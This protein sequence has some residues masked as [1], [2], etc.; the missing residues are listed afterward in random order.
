M[1]EIIAVCV[2]IYLWAVFSV[3]HMDEAD[4]SKDMAFCYLIYSD[5][6]TIS[7][8]RRER[9]RLEHGEWMSE[10]QRDNA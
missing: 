7:P 10:L 9:A 8:E 4:C 5:D 2:A 6:V 3:Y 1:F